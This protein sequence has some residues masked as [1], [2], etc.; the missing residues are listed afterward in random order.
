VFDRKTVRDLPLEGAQVLVRADYNVPQ[1]D[2]GDITDD[3]RLTA[4]LPTLEY[5]LQKRCKIVI[6]SHLGRP[7][8]Q[9]KQKYTLEPVAKM[10]SKLLHRPVKFVSDCVGDV[11]HMATKKMLPEEVVMFENLRFHPEEEANDRTFAHELAKASRAQFF[12]QDGFGVVHRAHASTAAITEF[13]PSAAGLLLERE[14]LAIKRA[15]DDPERPLV[16]VLGGAKISDKIELVERF[17]NISDHVIIG[18]AMAN[19]FLEFLKYPIG[20]SLYEPHMDTVVK[21]II[22]RAKAKY[23]ANFENSFMLPVDVAVSPTGEFAAQRENLPLDSVEPR[24]KILDIGD[25]SIE[26]ATEVI[27]AAGTVIWNGTLGMAEYPEF[28]HG[29]ARVAMAL[30]KNPH[31]VSVIG[32]GDTADFVR[33]WDVLKGG[34]F[35]HVST[36]GGASLELM[37]GET[38]PGIAAL[39]PR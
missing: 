36:G 5:L 26:R 11:A 22:T 31:I 10:L 23:G 38:L 7:D 30:A 1:D 39:L 14:Y 2:K 33:H 37:A 6:I 24:A 15:T 16:S 28:A 25:Q 12:I 29:S 27:A 13:L 32:G 35:T 18:G 9:V 3:F 17:V 34:S 4:S 19:N 21:R 20:E 8:G